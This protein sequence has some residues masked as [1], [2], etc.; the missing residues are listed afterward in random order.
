MRA[1]LSSLNLE[2]NLGT[3]RKVIEITRLK[4]GIILPKR[5][6]ILS[7]VITVLNT[8]NHKITELNITAEAIP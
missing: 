1:D 7:E 2:T 6:I 8:E 4:D 3:K 5:Q